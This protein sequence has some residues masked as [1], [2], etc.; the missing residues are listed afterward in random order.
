MMK[1]IIKLPEKWQKAVNTL[2]S[3]VLGENEKK[4]TNF[5]ANS[6]FGAVSLKY[7]EHYF[8]IRKKL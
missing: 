6:T 8:S 1:S 3:K 7:N 4:K 5:L 2:F